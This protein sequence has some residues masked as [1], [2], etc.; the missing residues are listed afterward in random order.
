MY[1]QRAVEVQ[2]C[3]NREVL[4]DLSDRATTAKLELEAWAEGE[5]I[6]FDTAS[7]AAAVE[8][9]G[10]HIVEED[11][12]EFHMLQA[13]G[14]ATEDGMQQL[15]EWIERVK[16]TPEASERATRMFLAAISSPDTAD[17]VQA[18]LLDS[19]LINIHAE[20]D[21]NERNCLHESV[22]AGCMFVFQAALERGV[23]CSRSDV[24]GRLPLHYAC[25]HGRTH[26]VRSLLD[27]DP[28]TINVFDHANFTPLIHAILRDQTSCVEVLL[29]RNARVE[30][31]APS[32]GE[33]GE[34]AHVPLNLAC[35]HASLPIVQ[36]LLQSKAKIR[37]D[38]EG[39]YPQH[40]VAK[41][42]RSA[43]ILLAL[44]DSGADLNQRDKVYSWPPLF[45]AASEGHANCLRTLLD[46]RVEIDV[47]D[48]K[49]LNAMYYAAWE[50]H[51]ECMIMLWE[52][53]RRRESIVASATTPAIG[54][55]ADKT[56][57]NGFDSNSSAPPVISS[58]VISEMAEDEMHFDS[59]PDLSL[60]PPIIPMRR[61]GHN[62]L[63]SKA[64]VQLYFDPLIEVNAVA[65]PPAVP[66]VPT[67]N[68][69]SPVGSRAPA[70]GPITFYQPGRYA[71]ARLTLS[72]K[73]SDLIPRTI[74]LPMNNSSDSAADQERI[75]TFQVDLER[76]DPFAL[77][78]EVFP[79]FGSKPIA[80]TVA[81][82][83]VFVGSSAVSEEERHIGKSGTC[84]LPLLDPRLRSIGEVKFNYMVIQPY[85]GEPLEITHFATY[86]KAT[87]TGPETDFHAHQTSNMRG[88]APSS[89]LL[90]SNAA[91]ATMPPAAAAGLV[92]GS[93][94]SG[95]YVQLFVQLTRDLVPV[96]YPHFDVNYF[97]LDI[98]VS[99]LT[100]AQFRDVI[101]ASLHQA[102]AQSPNTNLY[103]PPLAVDDRLR[104]LQALSESDLPLAH[105]LLAYSFLSL[106]EVLEYLPTSIN[107]NLCI[108]YSAPSMSA[109]C[110]TPSSGSSA[111]TSEKLPLKQ[112]PADINTYVDA[113][114]TDVFNHA[115]ASK[116][117][118]PDFMRSMVFTSFSADICI[119]LNWKQP[120]YP[121]FLCNDMGKFKDLA[122]TS[123]NRPV[124]ECSGRA[125][126]SVKESARVA[127]SNNFMG[128]ILRSSLLVS[129]QIY[130]HL[131]PV[132]RH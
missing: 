91:A 27:A 88:L 53:R 41:T 1:L 75:V 78:L 96:L 17:E 83:E 80:K 47:L 89:S 110:T 98:P 21:I 46:N 103:I 13:M 77:E 32:T 109:T 56:V 117:A 121:V 126:M 57:R 95:D 71:A 60:P 11:D 116:E 20:D 14:P 120:N 81:L 92:T 105:R 34:N 51:L 5:N 26:M 66:S 45:H 31:E 114:L 74:M 7:R 122:S 23:D 65:H 67:P 28:T 84:I 35:K 82:P 39:L 86:W 76:P 119:A 44:R 79:T 49:G 36:L 19:G 15:R 93:S 127:Q 58:T 118:N 64:F 33:D 25:M 6:Q 130:G 106:K 55:D 111:A 61:Y 132:S 73:N 70:T 16:A 101:P 22:I 29:S 112:P 68:S 43:E 104:T 59:L 69:S 63:E 40:I 9:V 97:G 10:P 24:Y 3:F 125:S 30:P 124:I 123:G 102:E 87:T 38:A 12:T 42:G 128:V 108:L 48:E 85:H 52:Q 54:R 113:I 94:L 107:V 100:Y 131:I 8:R 50:G 129:Y 115:R 4:R 37:P 90:S 62:F 2:P 72:S 99:N 18:V